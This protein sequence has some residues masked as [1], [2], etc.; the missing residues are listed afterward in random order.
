MGVVEEEAAEAV[1]WMELPLAAG[2][3]QTDEMAAL[4][5]EADEI[6]A[7]TVASIKTAR[8]KRP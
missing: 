2:V 5:R 4:M 3:V 1:Y 6:V 8:K 7:M